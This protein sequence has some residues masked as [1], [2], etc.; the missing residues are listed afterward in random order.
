VNFFL[1]QLAAVL[2]E[3]IAVGEELRRNL[4]AQK[5]AIVE[6]DVA[7]LLEQIEAREPRL[8]CL[9]QLEKKRSEI[10]KQMA[11]S[12]VPT[13][14]TQLLVQLPPNEV[15]YERLRELR[16]RARNIFNRLQADEK[17]LHGLMESLLE[18]IQEALRPLMLPSVSLYGDTGVAS[19]Q[20]PAAGLIQGKA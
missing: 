2:E 3:E 12:S 11:P 10:L 4:A 18:H 13:T 6:W 5:Q 16:E 9:S 20:R 1:N 7:Q 14:L 15:I 17:N 8:V 19:G